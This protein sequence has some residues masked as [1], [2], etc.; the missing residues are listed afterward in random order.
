VKD[1]SVLKMPVPWGVHKEQQQQWNGI[2]QSLE[3]YIQRA[4]LEMWPNSLG[5]GQQIM[6]RSQI[7]E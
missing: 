6:N 7:L 1:S 2:N 4:V 5:E 3:C